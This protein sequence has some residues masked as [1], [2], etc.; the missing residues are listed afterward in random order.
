MTQVALASGF[1][2]VRRFNA[3]FVAHYGLNPSALRRAGRRDRSAGVEVRLGYRPP[4]DVQRCW[5][6]SHP[7]ADRRH[8]VRRRQRAGAHAAPE[9]AGQVHAG[10]L[11][12]RFDESASRSC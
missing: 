9:H 8:R 12:A 2:S 1:A 10:W 3:A 7:R 6:S 11:V 4:Y 5:R